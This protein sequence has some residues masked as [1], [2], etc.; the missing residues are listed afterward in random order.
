MFR[1]KTSC[2][3]LNI[4]INRM[5]INANIKYMRTSPRK[6]REVA[7][8][9]RN[10]PLEQALVELKFI[11]KRAAGLLEKALKSALA[12]AEN[13]Y[14]LNKKNLK[15]KFLEINEG[16]SF[17]RWRPVSRG[18][19]HPYKKKTSHIKVVLTEKNGT[20]D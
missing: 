13:N 4:L 20:K 9:V 7:D 18:V 12:N 14:S 10:K 1:R 16:P 15:I 2:V 17:K 8:I 19:A 6:L 11:R 3:I 5:D